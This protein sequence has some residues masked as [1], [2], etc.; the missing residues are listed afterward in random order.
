LST[1]EINVIPDNGLTSQ[2]LTYNNQNTLAWVYS[3][4]GTW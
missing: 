4:G 3:D 2:V 1:S